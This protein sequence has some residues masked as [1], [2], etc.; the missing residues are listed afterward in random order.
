MELELKDYLRI[1][2]KRMWFIVVVILTASIL[3]GVVSYLWLQPVYQASTKLIVNK[4]NEPTAVGQLD[5]NSVNLNIRLIDTYKEIIKTPA[6][7]DKVVEEHPEFGLSSEQLTDRVRVS[8]VNNTQVMTLSVQDPSYLKAAEMA[9]A[10]SKMFIKEIPSIMK[11]DNVSFLAQADV[12]KTPAPVKPRPILNIAIAFVV[13]ALIAVSITFLLE[14]L[15]DTMRTE[16]DVEQ[17]LGYPVIGMIPKLKESEIAEARSQSKS[18]QG[19]EQHV[20][21]QSKI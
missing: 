1:L 18:R 21:V 14:Y 16:H 19:R 5:L 6:I 20:Q 12:H 3:T 10:I 15:D 4:S 2:R 9:N 13:S 11:V 17:Y 7:M 8:S